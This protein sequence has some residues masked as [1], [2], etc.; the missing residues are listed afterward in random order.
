[1]VND[2]SEHFLA[3]FTD[4]RDIYRLLTRRG[5]HIATLAAGKQLLNA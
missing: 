2:V 3:S 5:L 4:F 1:M